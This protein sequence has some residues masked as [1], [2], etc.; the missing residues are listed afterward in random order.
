MVG[1]ELEAGVGDAVADAD[2]VVVGV[3]VGE[4]E[5]VEVGAPVGDAVCACGQPS[6]CR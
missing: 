4:A 2:G 6:V 5:S 3:I 1:H